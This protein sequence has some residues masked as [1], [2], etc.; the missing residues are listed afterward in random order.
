MYE[1]YR[2]FPY[3]DSWYG[4]DPY[5]AGYVGAPSASSFVSGP[6]LAKALLVAGGALAI[7]FI[8]RASR[9]AEKLEP[10]HERAGRMAGKMLRA[11]YKRQGESKGL[12][13]RGDSRKL[14]ESR[15]SGDGQS[16]LL[17][18]TDYYKLTA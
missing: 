4:A 7:F 8:F 15:E 12:L 6:T 13:S 11:R 17:G 9:A 10:V 16:K 2:Y 3:D 5:D 1:D 18:S 14:L